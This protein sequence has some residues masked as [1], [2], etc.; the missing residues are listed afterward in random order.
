[1]KPIFPVILLT[2][3]A[4]AACG[5]GASDNS[6]P[7]ESATAAPTASPTATPPPTSSSPEPL[8]VSEAAT[9]TQ[10]I[11]PEEDGPLIDGVNI[12]AGMSSGEAPDFALAEETAA[13]LTSIMRHADDEL[14]PYLE[15]FIQPLDD[16]GAA[17]RGELPAGYD[18][19]IEEWKAA[20]TELLTR[21]E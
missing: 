2:S 8:V 12:V 9:C 15:V 17:S 5:Q 1:M 20:G 6:T 14:K 19:D 18:L 13:E 10:L 3:L 16:I 7:V 21:C 11:G 4:V